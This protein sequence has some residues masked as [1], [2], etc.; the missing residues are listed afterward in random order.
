[1]AY[2]SKYRRAPGA[3][4]IQRNARLPLNPGVIPAPKGLMGV[5]L[6]EFETFCKKRK[7][8][9]SG[10]CVLFKECALTLKAIEAACI[11]FLVPAHNLKLRTQNLK[12]CSLT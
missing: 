7:I 9:V 1:M 10:E 6:T 8:K 2:S 11:H 5:K 3:G 4:V 12:V